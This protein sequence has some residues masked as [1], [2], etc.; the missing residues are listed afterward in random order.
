MDQKSLQSLLSTNKLQEFQE[1]SKEGKDLLIEELWEG[2]KAFLAATFAQTTKKTVVIVTEE[3]PQNHFLGDL[4]YFSKIPRLE[5][6]AWEMLPSEEITPSSDIIG[7]RYQVLEKLGKEKSQHFIFTTLQA[8]LQKVPLP[9]KLESSL[10]SFKK[11]ES[12]N[13]DDMASLLAELGYMRAKVCSEKGTFAVRGG[14]IDIF[15]S[16]AFTPFRLEFFGNE[17]ESIRSFDPISQLSI[18]KVSSISIT[19]NDELKFLGTDDTHATLFDYLGPNIALLFDDLFNLEDK[20]VQLQASIKENR[21]HY[22]GLDEFQSLIKEKQKLYFTEEPLEALS[23]ITN[24]DKQ[25]GNLYSDKAKSSLISFEALNQKWTAYRWRHPF[26]PVFSTFCPD[27]VEVE[28]ATCNQI[29][30]SATAT[31]YQLHFVSSLESERRSIK[32]KLGHMVE[33]VTFHEGSLSHGFCVQEINFA[34]LSIPE[35]FHKTI[36]HR[37]KHRSHGQGQSTQEMFALNPGEAIVHMSSGIGR[38]LGVEKRLNHLGVETEFLLVEY[39]QGAKLYVPIEQTHLVSKYIGATETPPELHQ[40]GSTKWK[41]ALQKSEKAIEGY[42]KEL[43]QLQAERALRG[44]YVYPEDSELVKQFSEEF[45]YTETTDQLSAIKSVTNDMMSG[46]SMDR[47]VCGDVGYGKTEVAM[48]AAVKAVIDGGKQ[49]AI[50]VPTTVLAMQHFESFSQRM[51]GFPIVLG[52][53]SR[54]RSPKENKQTIEKIAEGKIDIVVGTHRIISKDVIFKNLGLIIID[55]EQRFGVKAKEHLKTLKKDVD[56]LTLSAT[57][58]PRTLYLSLSGAREMSV[59]NTPPEERLPIQSFVTQPSDDVIKTALLRELSRD[60]QA[61]FVHN[62]VETIFE[63]ASYIRTLLP[64]ARIVVGH[65]QM[66]ADELDTVFHTYKSG[67]ADIL[68]A[69]SII[70]NGIDI[71]NANTMI[72]DRADRFGLSD[73]YQ[74]RG[75]VGRWNR[76]A[77]CY[78]LV[79]SSFMLNE[80][81]RKRLSAL[82]HSSGYGGG[83]K[84]AMHDLE[85]RG[86]GNLLGTEQSGHIA[87]IGFT[88]YCKLLRKTMNMMQKKGTFMPMVDVKIEFPYDARLPSTYVNE[89]TLRMEFY[90]RLGEAES[91][92]EIDMLFKE[93]EDRFGKPPIEV[94]WLYR[95]GRIRLFA[96]LNQF[97]LLKMTKV[98]LLAE[99]MVDKKKTI[100]KKMLISLPKTPQELETKVISELKKNFP[101]PL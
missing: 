11:G 38:Y 81:A 1:L 95:V 100:S 76:K 57:P 58:I 72:I 12:V 68:V 79:P 39:A 25:K 88:L 35:L 23:E 63:R 15:P 90:Q 14:I 78:F 60:G 82:V 32:E 92:E 75:R 31:P 17:I 69:T 41:N 55:E 91:N 67:N 30:E 87:S 64:D 96:A 83:M 22:I 93:L 21:R 49:V 36:V 44:G 98:V 34:L 66:S 54:F 42:A 8:L 43:L 46:N 62:R 13:F 2:P 85:I 29:L 65:G 51:E 37:H 101:L 89:I 48:R 56:C 5:F 61:Y 80:I 28:N 27:N 70:E 3:K 7:E 71:P 73:L 24:L 26:Q 97:T 40:L 4:G 6:P 45:P 33:N 77:Y 52:Q 86:A 20:Y 18:E 53:L 16:S 99:Q 74:M 10:M 84:V 50:L 59:I 9:K 47:L 94:E 19:P